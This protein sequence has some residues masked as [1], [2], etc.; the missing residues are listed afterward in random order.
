LNVGAKALTYLRSLSQ[1][2]LALNVCWD[3]R[4]VLA[5][6]AGYGEVLIEFIPGDADAV[7]H[8][9]PLGALL[10]GRGEE[11]RETHEGCAEFA[12]IGENDAESL[13]IGTHV[14]CA[15]IRLND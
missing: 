14:D 15:C 6:E 8:E 5:E 12:T 3:R 11:T 4:S 10:G 7:A 2:Y 13:G 1:G 9:T